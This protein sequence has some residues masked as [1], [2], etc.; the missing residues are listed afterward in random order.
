MRRVGYALFVLA[1]V[2]V[3]IGVVSLRAHVVGY[4]LVNFGFAV[5]NTMLGFVLLMGS[6]MR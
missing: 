4:G 5:V 2:S 1:G 6:R 3:V